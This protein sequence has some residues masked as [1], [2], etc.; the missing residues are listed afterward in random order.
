M[1]ENPIS[2]SSLNDFI[3]CPVSIYFHMLEREENILF[4]D[5]AQIN[6][7]YAHRNSDTAAYSTKKSMLQGVSVYCRKY[8]LCGKIDV[9]DMDKGIL[10]ERKKKI[11]T[12]YDGYIFQLYAQYFSL[13]EMGYDVK[14]IRLYSM[15][16]N[17]TY[18]IDLPDNNPIMRDKFKKLLI[19]VN[20]FSFDNFKQTNV[21]KCNNCIYEPLCSFSIKKGGKYNVYRT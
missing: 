11:K 14:K 18:D 3:F 20:A 8:N 1:S 2:I 15:D 7:T 4:Q 16:T 12:I 6:G 9:F 5:T 13:T 17:K 19:D 10:T 21:E